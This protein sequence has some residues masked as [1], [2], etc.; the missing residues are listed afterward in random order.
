M[1]LA[2]DIRHKSSLLVFPAR[3]DALSSG[4]ASVCGRRRRLSLKNRRNVK[5]HYLA[6][7][8][9]VARAKS[10]KRAQEA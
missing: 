7:E 10:G 5:M 3:W 9:T 1:H 2:F 4:R 8:Q 6:P